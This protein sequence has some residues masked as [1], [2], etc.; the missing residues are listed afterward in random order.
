MNTMMNI[1]NIVNI[2]NIIN[3]KNM[4]GD[5]ISIDVSQISQKMDYTVLDLKRAYIKDIKEDINNYINL[6]NLYN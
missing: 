2:I 4:A 6:F 5:M 1:V 3:I